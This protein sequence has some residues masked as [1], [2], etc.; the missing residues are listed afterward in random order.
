VRRA[1]LVY[2]ADFVRRQLTSALASLGI[3]VPERM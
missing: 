3:E 1:V 2:V